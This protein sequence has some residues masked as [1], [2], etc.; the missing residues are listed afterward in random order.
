M[1]DLTAPIFDP[2]YRYP[3]YV[4]YITTLD[5]D[6]VSEYGMRGTGLEELDEKLDVMRVKVYITI[7]RMVELYTENHPISI[8]NGL[9]AKQIYEAITT[10]TQQWSAYIKGNSLN[11]SAI[12]IDD[13]LDLEEFAMRIRPHAVSAIDDAPVE[14]GLTNLLDEYLTPLHNV[15]LDH[16]TGLLEL[17]RD[18]KKRMN[19]YA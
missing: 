8:C 6:E 3:C 12:P 17:F 9:A 13:L 7:A 1:S 5:M 18:Y 4:P 14:I 16:D 10:Y 2:I 19:N 15:V 11:R